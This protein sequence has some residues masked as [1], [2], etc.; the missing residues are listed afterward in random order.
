VALIT[1]LSEGVVLAEGKL[2]SPFA[3]W[4]GEQPA[5][6]KPIRMIVSKFFIGLSVL[7][8]KREMG[9]AKTF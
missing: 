3:G 5:N 8:S 1:W 7:P 6:M 4:K 2:A 9:V